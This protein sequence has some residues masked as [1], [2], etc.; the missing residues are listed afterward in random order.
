[1]I[2]EQSQKNT[3]IPL[4]NLAN[5]HNF[6]P[7]QEVLYRDN[8]IGAQMWFIN[9]YEQSQNDEFPNG[10][11]FLSFPKNCFKFEENKGQKFKNGNSWVGRKIKAPTKYFETDPRFAPLV[12]EV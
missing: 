7:N 8:T 12:S 6:K 10:A 1:M 2:K 5:P 9:W 11:T 3:S 4:L